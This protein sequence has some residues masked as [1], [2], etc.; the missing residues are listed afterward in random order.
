M[1]HPPS[2]THA[3]AWRLA[4]FYLL[5]FMA[6]GITLPFLPWYFSTLGLS[7]SQSGVLLAVGPTFALVA[8]PLWGHLADRTGR[9]G[10]VL[11]VVSAGA[12]VGFGLLSAAAAFGAVLAALAA[13]WAFASATSTLIDTLTLQHVERRGGSYPAIRLWGSLGF[14]VSA[15]A[16]G[17]RAVVDGGAVLVPLALMV[18]CAAWAGA[19][20]AGAPA[21]RPEGPRATAAQAVALASRGEVRLVLAATAL[22]WI[23]CAPYNGTL[24]VHLKALGLSPQTVSACAAAGVVAEIAVMWT[25]PR[26]S[27]RVSAHALL[28]L[29]FLA[30]ALRWWGMSLTSSAPA[31]VALSL[32]HGLTFGAFFVAAV[33]WM[34]A[35]APG[36]LRAT[37]Q[38]LLVAGT[39]GVGGLVGYL[40]A[41]RAY[42]ALGGHRLFAAA[43]ALELAPAA[44]LLVAGW[45][46][47]ARGRGGVNPPGP[48]ASTG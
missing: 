20:L 12:A 33:A 18:A 24:P 26:W 27:H 4:V 47:R 46:A 17:Q 43:A 35:Q 31:L 1:E 16:F 14:V 42:D 13:H 10:A 39:F 36:S 28:I 9:P 25:W 40:L 8:P 6:L 44:L 15:L 11:V 41:G 21:H 3:G 19:M 2:A 30:S 22:H 45:R 38:S 32:L 7:A 5:Q 23:A 48:R 29:S 34:A 37:G